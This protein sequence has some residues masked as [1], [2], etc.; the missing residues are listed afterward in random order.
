MK[1][2]GN[3]LAYT[4]IC[5]QDDAKNYHVWQYRQWLIET[6]PEFRTKELNFTHKLLEEDF[7]NNSAWNQRYFVL[8]K[9]GILSN[10]QS[11]INESEFV[12]KLIALSLH[13]ESAWNYLRGMNFL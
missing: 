3:E 1:S 10:E 9:L 5:L 11:V 4:A 8:F 12:K 13:N 7:R 2:P 6:Y